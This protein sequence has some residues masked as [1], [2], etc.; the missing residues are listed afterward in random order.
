MNKSEDIN[1]YLND[2][3][4]RYI[5][6]MFEESSDYVQDQ[7]FSLL[8]DDVG[9]ERSKELWSQSVYIAKMMQ[10]MDERLAPLR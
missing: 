6:F 8:E 5:S 3:M 9:V 1:N 4:V 2:C 10:D 7:V